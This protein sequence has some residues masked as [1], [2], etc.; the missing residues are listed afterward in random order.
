MS[1]IADGANVAED[2]EDEREDRLSRGGKEG[3]R[4]AGRIV[5]KQSPSPFNW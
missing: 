5:L 2:W 4:E 3:G 1:K